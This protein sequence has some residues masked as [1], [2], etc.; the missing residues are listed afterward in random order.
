MYPNLKLEIFKRGLH[1]NHLARELGL[2]ETVLSKIIRGCREPSESQKQK[3]ASYL[4]VETS[5][6]FEKFSAASPARLS[7]AA[8]SRRGK[9]NGDL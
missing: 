3:L 4:D 7:T 8:D 6:L 1:Q 5:W 9:N 2:D